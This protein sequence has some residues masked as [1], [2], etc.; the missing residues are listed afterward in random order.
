MVRRIEANNACQPLP[1]LLAL[2][3]VWLESRQSRANW[4]ETAMLAGGKVVLYILLGVSS[5][6]LL[7]STSSSSTWK[8]QVRSG[9]VQGSKLPRRWSIAA[10]LHPPVR[11]DLRPLTLA[12]RHNNP[13]SRRTTTS[14]PPSAHRR[15]R[16]VSAQVPGSC[17]IAHRLASD[18]FTPLRNFPQP[19]FPPRIHESFTYTP[20]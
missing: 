5:S 1:R 11:A 18:L 13:P 17:R 8:R 4:S 10:E 15:G 20:C 14:P 2:S 16:L 3:S 7:L 12:L 19:L 6:Y 9:R